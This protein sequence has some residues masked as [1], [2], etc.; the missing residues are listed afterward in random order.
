ML[1]KGGCSAVRRVPRRAITFRNTR[2]GR[3]SSERT[4]RVRNSGTTPM[5]ISSSVVTGDFTST[6]ECPATLA[7]G[8]SCE[9]KVR[10]KPT[11][12][13]LRAGEFTLASNAAGSPHVVKLSGQAVAAGG[14]D[15][16]CDDDES[17]CSQS[18]LPFFGRSR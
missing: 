12:L 11:A 15:D 1:F 2:L 16:D 4:I 5:E 3:T 18:V 8:K 7:P 6:S 9:F 10:F 17:A 14:K 13:G